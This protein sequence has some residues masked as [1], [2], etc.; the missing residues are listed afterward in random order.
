MGDTLRGTCHTS[1]EVVYGVLRSTTLEYSCSYVHG[2]AG[3]GWALRR[4]LVATAAFPRNENY[5]NYR[6]PPPGDDSCLG[7]V[8]TPPLR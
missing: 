4:R 2:E 6:P 8:W 5:R 1:E 3:E 7:G